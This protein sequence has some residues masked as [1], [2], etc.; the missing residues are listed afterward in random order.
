LEN[1]KGEIKRTQSEAE[2]YK[3]EAEENKDVVGKITKL[4]E[5][6]AALGMIDAS[7]AGSEPETWQ[8]MALK[9]GA[10]LLQNLPSVIDNIASLAR[11]RNSQDL[12]AA[13][14]QGRRDMI[15]Q[16]SQAPMALP[17]PHRRRGPPQ[18]TGEFIPRHISEVAPAP[19]PMMGDPLVV[20]MP[21]AEQPVPMATPVSQGPSAMPYMTGPITTGM[22]PEPQMQ[23]LA[24]VTPAVAP[25]PSIAPP[26]A[27]P[28]AP[29]P[30]EAEAI[31]QDR[32]MLEAVPILQAQYEANVPTAAIAQ[33]ALEQLGPQA[34]TGLL[35]SLGSADRFI[36]ALERSGDPNSPFLRRD[37]KKFLRGLFEEFGKVLGK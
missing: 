28:S 34:L 7:E 10:G 6:A 16:V 35:Q 25:P 17:P 13:R 29:S 4:K 31:A 32:H 22:P 12:Q 1:T 23:P 11:G 18:L 30:S 33:Q 20:P 37:G 19:R 9:T 14:V 36:L 15:E 24:P 5:D 8:Q 27:G 21:M 3:L 2:R 26:V